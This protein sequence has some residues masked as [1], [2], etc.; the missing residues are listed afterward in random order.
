MTFLQ[1][2]KSGATSGLGFVA[3][4]GHF[5]TF[6]PLAAAVWRFLSVNRGYTEGKHGEG[7]EPVAHDGALKKIQS[8]PINTSVT[9]HTSVNRLR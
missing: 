5:G 6:L 9:V 7:W 1:K 4:C 3:F 8:V 2:Q